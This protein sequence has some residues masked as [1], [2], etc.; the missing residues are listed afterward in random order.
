[1]DIRG[2]EVVSAYEDA[3]ILV[4]LFLEQECTADK[5]RRIKVWE[6]SVS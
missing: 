2:F 1:M 4:P 6:C 3:D 5:L